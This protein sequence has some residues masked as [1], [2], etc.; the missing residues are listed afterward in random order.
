MAIALATAAT[1]LVGAPA[2]PAD[3][4][5][6][7]NWAGY[8]SHRPGVS[9][10]RVIGTW[11]VSPPT[12]TARRRTYSSAWVGLGGF[13]TSAGALEQI[14]TEADCTASGRAALSSWY[15][16]VPAASRAI[17]L[18]IDGGDRLR[19]SVSVTGHE[20]TLRLA[21]L[22]RHRSF[23]RTQRASDVDTSSAEWI[24]E[25][26]SVCSG[27]S[28]CQT[29]PL[30]DF[31]STVFDS[32]AAESAAGHTGTIDD[33]R[34]ATTM[35]SLTE[36]G[37]RFV[38]TAPGASGSGVATATPSALARNG[39]AFAVT[40]KSGATAATPGAAAT[41]N[42]AAARLVHAGGL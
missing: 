18:R 40:F 1:A 11:T 9:F 10:T 22:T 32:A 36:S 20:V 6:S 5:V 31:G 14:G 33:R 2:A 38:G 42:V 21:N 24:V 34:W 41:A 3:T 37:H 35:I 7:S 16:L 29:L 39:S 28:S 25:A 19:A 23:I 8:A 17:R 15:E 26:P 12:C 30:A 4:S 13:T 27:S